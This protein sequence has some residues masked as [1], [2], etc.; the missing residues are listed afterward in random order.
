MQEKL[1]KLI[2]ESKT[3]K[4][5][6]LKFM[7]NNIWR[8]E[9][10]LPLIE[11]K[12]E[13]LN[14][15]YDKPELKQRL[16]HIYNNHYNVVKCRYCDKPAKLCFAINSNIAYHKSCGSKPCTLE[17]RKETCLEK[18]GF[19][20][21]GQSQIVKDRYNQTRSEKYGGIHPSQTKEAKE[22]RRKTNIERYGVES[23]MQSSIIKD[24]YNNTCMERHGVK[25]GSSTKK[26]RENFIQTCQ[27]KYGTNS[28]LQAKEVTDKIANT[29]MER[30]GVTNPAYLESSKIKSRETQERKYGGYAS[31]TKEFR[32]KVRQTSLEKFGVEH[33][34]QNEEV[35]S[36]RRETNLDRYGV[37]CNLLAEN[38]IEKS[39]Q[40]CVEKYGTDNYSHTEEYSNRMKAWHLGNRMPVI[41]SFVKLGY[42]LVDLN[43]GLRITYKCPTCGLE[44]T[45]HL[46][47]FMQRHSS[48]SEICTNCL[49]IIT[50]TSKA[51]KEVNSYVQSLGFETDENNRSILNGKE[52]DVYVPSKKVGFEYNGLYWHGENN[53]SSKYHQEK[54]LQSISK[55]INL[56]HIWE[57][58]WEYKRDIIESRIRNILGLSERIYAR[59][60]SVKE[61]DSKTS[62]EFLNDNH[63][64]GN[65]NA[66]YHFGLFFN[67]ELVSVM[68]F[69]NRNK[70]IEML[71]FANKLNL[72]VVGG[73]SKLL[74]HYTRNYQPEEIFTF[75]DLDWTTPVDNVYLK[76]GF[77]YNSI[78]TPSYWWVKGDQ[79]F[80][81][82]NFQKHKLVEQGYDPNMTE[83]DIMYQRGFTKVHN[84]GNLKYSLKV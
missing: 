10:V 27:K 31:S 52:I 32:D 7:S 42:E 20:N 19:E 29:L 82:L 68:T 25:N 49:P 53:K 75:A 33:Y 66:K 79:R 24:K 71:R 59:Q 65:L 63:L 30:Y 35:I 81:R 9:D 17:I 28:P 67:N 43:D 36:K 6:T 83:D 41:E 54:K 60:T 23:P 50:F 80:N 16:W 58:D 4:I 62:E 55:G 76:N 78:T 21:A 34:L 37:T 44:F 84:S 5:L 3:F 14:D 38:N 51:E 47:F 13:F 46:G 22:K 69:A 77:E 11:R 40:T 56:V 2:K 72:N 18:F 26:A 15:Y 64:Q 1:D 12:T 48:G 45:H 39:R 61:L 74:K 57:D 73:F 70:N 8:N